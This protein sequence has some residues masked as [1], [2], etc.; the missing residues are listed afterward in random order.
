MEVS[1]VGTGLWGDLPE[2]GVTEGEAAIVCWGPPERRVQPS[3]QP[4]LPGCCRGSR[5]ACPAALSCAF[6]ACSPKALPEAR[7]PPAPPSAAMF[8]PP[9]PCHQSRSFYNGRCPDLKGA[10]LSG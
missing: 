3:L 10:A 4:G 1:R 8:P 7:V 5:A 9:T 2:D 6:G